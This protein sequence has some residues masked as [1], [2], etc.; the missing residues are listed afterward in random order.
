[1]PVVQVKYKIGDDGDHDEE[2]GRLEDTD[3]EKR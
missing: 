2:G 1:M 3:D